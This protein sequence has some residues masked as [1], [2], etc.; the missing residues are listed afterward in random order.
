MAQVTFPEDIG[1]DGNT[2]SDDADPQTGMENG[3]HRL[4]FIP[5]MA[6]IVGV[7]L[8]VKAYVNN[9]AQLEQQVAE[10]TERAQTARVEAEAL[11]GDLQAVE[12]AAAAT[13]ENKNL[14][15]SAR[16]GAE[17]AQGAAESAASN[18]ASEVGAA[19]HTHVGEADPHTQYATK[20]QLESHENNTDPHSQYALRQET[21]AA[22]ASVNALLQSDDTTLD[23]L[24]EI[25]EYIKLNRA[26][27]D[28]LNIDAI[29]GLRAALE[30]KAALVHT[31]DDRY[32]TQQQIDNQPKGD[33]W[34]RSA[35]TTTFNYDADGLITGMTENV[36]GYL[37]TTTYTYSGGVISQSSTEFQ[38]RVRTETYTYDSGTLQQSTATITEVP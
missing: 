18:A 9:L 37:R 34:T 20:T 38:G 33:P 12:S 11:Y 23:E 10:N 25:V 32:Y 2:Y 14:A 19:L 29:A 15:V 13:L 1:G 24:Q 35:D 5:A 16:Q 17:E 30:G 6:N 3:G 31:H 27:L 7:G 4:R 8:Y 26:D 28:A 21:Q 36:G 22:L